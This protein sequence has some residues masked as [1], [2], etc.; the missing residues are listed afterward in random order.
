MKKL[1]RHSEFEKD[2]KKIFYKIG[3]ATL[4]V[5]AQKINYRVK[6]QAF[7]RVAYV[8]MSIKGRNI[9]VMKKKGKKRISRKII[10]RSRRI[11]GLSSFN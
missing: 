7:K 3:L 4:L 10:G 8:P 9:K 5:V 2:S 6:G 11:L 1:S